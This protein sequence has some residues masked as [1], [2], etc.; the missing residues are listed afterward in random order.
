M[1]FETKNL[2]TAVV[3]SAGSNDMNGT[4]GMWGATSKQFPAI[5][6]VDY[7]VRVL[8]GAITGVT[9]AN[10]AATFKLATST[11]TKTIN[12]THAKRAAKKTLPNEP[13]TTST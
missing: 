10:P 9:G 3:T 6:A 2:N 12:R 5:P 7:R 4:T 1:Q 11:D 8:V 13:K